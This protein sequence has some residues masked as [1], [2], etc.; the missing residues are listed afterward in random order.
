MKNV[1]KFFGFPL[2]TGN[3]KKRVAKKY[4]NRE[5]IKAH[6]KRFQKTFANIGVGDLINDC[7]GFNG[8]IVRIDPE[9]G[10]IPNGMILCNVDFQT[11]NTGCS[12]IHCGVSAEL[13][14][15]VVETRALD[16]IENWTLGK[17]GET[18]YGGFDNSEFQHV[19][20]MARLKRDILKS[21]GHITDDRGRLLPE[22]KTSGDMG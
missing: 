15:E 11:T 17:P 10:F 12:L 14:Q 1:P 13:P 16:F 3:V 21:G 2:W 9:Y 6:V 20:E 5:V 8:E 4:L 22:F 19:F 18:W 7:T